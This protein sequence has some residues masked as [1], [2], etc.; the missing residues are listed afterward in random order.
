MRTAIRVLSWILAAAIL[1]GATTAAATG[2]EKPAGPAAP[3][4]KAPNEARLAWWRGARFGMFIHWGPVS[5]KGTEIGWSRGAEIPIAEYD[6]LYKQFN[7]VKF[8]ADQWVKIAKDAGMKYMVFTSKHHDGFCMFDTHETDFNVMHSPFGRDVVKELS[9]ACRKQGIAFGTYYSVCDWHHPDFPLGSP[10]GT[11]KKPHPDLDRYEQYLRKQVE[12]LVRNYGPLS[13]LWFDVA[14]CFDAKRGQGVVDFTRSLQPDILVNNRCANPGDYDTPEQT[15]GTFRYDRPWETCMTICNQWAW[16]PGDPMKSLPQ[17]VQTL[18]RCA[19]GDGNLLFNV[20]PMPSGEI[21]PRQ[22]ERLRQMGAWLAKYGESIYGTR[23]GP[24]KPNRQI[25]STRRGNTV[26]VHVLSWQ[27]D[28]IVLPPLPKKIIGCSLLTGGIVGVVQNDREIT[29]GAAKPDRQEIDTIVKLELDGPAL[30]IPPASLPTNI[31]ATA[32]NVFQR[33]EDYGPEMA[34]DGDP[35]T[36]W[37][38]DGGTKQAWIAIDLGKPLTLEGVKIEEE[39]APRVEKFGLQYK[40]G[41]EW[42]TFFT[43]TKLGHF[44]QKFPPVT[45][46]HLRLNILQA[47][48]GPTISEIQWIEK[49]ATR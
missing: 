7:P 1:A 39:Y 11:T 5:L 43:G 16:K 30:D 13:T 21:E 6:N 17:C 42:K 19:G 28:S 20:G 45:A 37:A 24:F 22:V 23:G 48:E 27:G 2:A 26:Y 14:Q 9:E 15:V 8:N 34:F 47:N 4:V 32:S 38:T 12:E 29:I 40:D 33:M 3:A 49:G 46:R 35:H 25:A 10:G 31:K 18:V 36:R 41:S 44:S